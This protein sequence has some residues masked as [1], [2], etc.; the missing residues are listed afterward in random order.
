MRPAQQRLEPD[1]PPLAQIDERLVDEGEL[2]AFLHSVQRVLEPQPPRRAGPPL[3]V[4]AAR[5]VRHAT[6][7]ADQR[8]DGRVDQLVGRHDRGRGRHAE[9]RGDRHRVPIH[10]ERRVRQHGVQPRDDRRALRV[11]LERVAEHE[12]LVT[13]EPAR[14]VAAPQGGRHP[15][16]DR[17][18]QLVPGGVP[19]RVVDELE[20]VEA[21]RDHRARPFAPHRPG[22]RARDELP[23]QRPAREPGQPVAQVLPAARRAS[24]TSTA[25]A[26]SSSS[27]CTSRS[28]HW[29][30]TLSIAQNAPSV[31]PPESV[32]G[33]PA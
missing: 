16:R 6:L 25:R 19:E 15:R 17:R 23:E 28:V 24:S 13:R 9:R 12:E 31:S 11:V 1:E 5:R 30:G 21:E 29:C 26:A 14:R 32:S 4:R 18:Q 27:R 20:P 10:L 3:R 2:V 33:M 8:V 7:A 22:D